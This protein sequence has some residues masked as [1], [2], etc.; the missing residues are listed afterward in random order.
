[1]SGIFSVK[2]LIG[3]VREKDGA[4]ADQECAA[5]ILMYARANIES[6]GVV[7]RR[8]KFWIAGGRASVDKVSSLLLRLRLGP[9]DRSPSRTI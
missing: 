3:E 8:D 4:A 2:P 6:V 1:V 7:V 5:A 9:K